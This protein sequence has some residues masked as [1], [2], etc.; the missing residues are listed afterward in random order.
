VTELL[1]KWK[2]E[3]TK[4]AS[5]TDNKSTALFSSAVLLPLGERR[6]GNNTNENNQKQKPMLYIRSLLFTRIIG[7][8]LGKHQ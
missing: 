5:K 2:R 1:G 8:A 6:E 7:L 4:K 3:K